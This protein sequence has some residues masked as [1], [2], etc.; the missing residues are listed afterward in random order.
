MSSSVEGPAG[1]HA[2]ITIRSHD[3]KG[4]IVLLHGESDLP[5]HR[6]EL[7]SVIGGSYAAEKLSLYSKDWYQDQGID[8]R[9]NSHVVRLSPS[10]NT[11]ELHT[12]DSVVYDALLL[13]TGAQPAMGTWPGHDLNGVMT[14]RTWH[15]AQTLSWPV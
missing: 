14:L 6:T 9:L 15:D 10:T 4:S 7:D 13:A 12:G 5:Y 1:V 3:P 11:L 2:A 8:L